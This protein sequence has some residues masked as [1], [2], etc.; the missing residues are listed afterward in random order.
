MCDTE[1][2]FIKILCFS[3]SVSNG[4]GEQRLYNSDVKDK[5]YQHISDN[6]RIKLI[7]KYIRKKYYVLKEVRQEL[8]KYQGCFL[9]EIRDI[10]KE[11]Y[12]KALKC[13]TTI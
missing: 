6:R 13:R 9:N 7:K 8:L 12:S 1:T 3:S 5:T 10:K 11:K 2:N 4:A